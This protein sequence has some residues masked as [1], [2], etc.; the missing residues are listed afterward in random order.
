MMGS[1]LVILDF[2]VI[3]VRVLDVV[4]TKAIDDNGKVMLL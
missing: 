2:I 3:N 4:D 1:H